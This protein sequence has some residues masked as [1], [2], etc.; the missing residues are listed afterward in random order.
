MA[1]QSTQGDDPADA[2][3]HRFYDAKLPPACQR[4]FDQDHV[5]PASLIT[6]VGRMAGGDREALLLRN[7]EACGKLGDGFDAMK[8]R[9]TQ[10]PDDILKKEWMRYRPPCSSRRDFA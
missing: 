10:D 5:W 3:P 1:L 8:I 2:P 7:T 9:F 6:S 4:I